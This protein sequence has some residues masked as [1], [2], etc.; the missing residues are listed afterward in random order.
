MPYSD[1]QVQREHQKLWKRATKDWF[2]RLKASLS[3]VRCGFDHPAA[4]HFHHPT[5]KTVEVSRMV[6]RNVSRAK[7][8]AEIAKCEVICA[9]CHAIEHW[10][11]FYRRARAAI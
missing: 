3:C 11:Q 4:L 7:I 10:D 1:P 5:D 6:N 9:N 2:W 8:E